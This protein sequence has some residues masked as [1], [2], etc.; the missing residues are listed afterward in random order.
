MPQLLV[1]VKS[2]A[3]NSYKMTVPKQKEMTF[4]ANPS[5]A[6]ICPLDKR[7]TRPQFFFRN[8]RLFLITSIQLFA[9]NSE[10]GVLTIFSSSPVFVLTVLLHHHH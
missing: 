6:H 9:G 10:T 2:Y 7:D 1:Q 8:C 4:K 5:Q 3:A